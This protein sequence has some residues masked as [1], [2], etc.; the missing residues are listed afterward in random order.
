MEFSP[1]SLGA[2]TC[3]RFKHVA[4]PA[5]ALT[6]IP[7]LAL[8]SDFSGLLFIAYGITAIVA[9]IIGLIAHFS[10]KGV[11]SIAIRAIVWGSFV[12]M[13]FTPLSIDGGNGLSHG[14]PLLNMLTV[15]FGADPAYGIGALKVLAISAPVCIGVVAWLIWAAPRSESAGNNPDNT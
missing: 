4:L 15:V 3:L 14:P 12:A 10:T 9:L 7:S 8:A 2:M 6:L 13:V 5:G 1:T 11:K